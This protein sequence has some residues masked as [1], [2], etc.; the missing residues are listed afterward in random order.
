MGKVDTALAGR[1]VSTTMLPCGGAD[2]W[3]GVDAL[4]VL[5]DRHREEKATEGKKRIKPF[6]LCSMRYG[7]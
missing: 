5:H 1:L 6:F 7:A 4:W 2:G 3:L